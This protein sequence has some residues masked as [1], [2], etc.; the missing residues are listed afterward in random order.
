V[1]RLSLT[2][3]AE[4]SGAHINDL[5]RYEKL[6]Q[7]PNVRHLARI[8]KVIGVEFRCSERGWS[9]GPVGEA[10]ELRERLALAR[11]A[12]KALWLEACLIGDM[13][14]Q[15]V[16][17]ETKAMCESVIGERLGDEPWGQG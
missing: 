2:K 10:D 13:C 5:C 8:A 4:E 6:K 15:G 12:I 14:G 11:D 17:D 16:G 1:A 3:L 9:T 7:A